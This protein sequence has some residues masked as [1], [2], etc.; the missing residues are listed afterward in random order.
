MGWLAVGNSMALIMKG[1][2]LA[3]GE[4]VIQYMQPDPM[5]KMYAQ[6]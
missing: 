6:G 2:V 3:T 4:F 1:F 5:F